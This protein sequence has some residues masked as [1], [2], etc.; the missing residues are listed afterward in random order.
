MYINSNPKPFDNQFIKP[1]I[2]K[3]NVNLKKGA[4][5]IGDKGYINKIKLVTVK[6]KNQ[7]PNNA[8]NKK[9]IQ[10]NRYN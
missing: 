5:I 4:A 1:S 3:L 8:K 10:K 2:S 9:I 7:I 6:R